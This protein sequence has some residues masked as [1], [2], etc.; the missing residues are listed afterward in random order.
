M[1]T[2]PLTAL[3]A[4]ATGGPGWA[5]RDRRAVAMLLAGEGSHVTVVG[6]RQQPLESV[7]GEMGDG[8]MV[9]A[10]VASEAGVAAVLD[11]LTATDRTYAGVV[12]AAG[13]VSP[14]PAEGSAITDVRRDWLAAFESNAL[15]AVLLVEALARGCTSR[16]AGWCCCPRSPRCVALAA[17]PM[18][19]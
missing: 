11:H 8:G 7:R 13:G 9:V 15:T 12:A 1:T 4:S 19:R 5:V 18:A 2:A 3:D 16:L 14:T 17:A 10:D 6:R